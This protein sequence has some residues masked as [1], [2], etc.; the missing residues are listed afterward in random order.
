MKDLSENYLTKKTKMNINIKKEDILEY[1]TRKSNY[2]AIEKIIDPARYEI[3]DCGIY[4]HD[5]Q[6]M[7]KQSCEYETYCSFVS[8]LRKTAKEM[9]SWEIKKVC[10]EIEEIAPKEINLND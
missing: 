3:F 9:S 10:E 6:K 1:V 2:D 5:K 7:L 4:D 8:N